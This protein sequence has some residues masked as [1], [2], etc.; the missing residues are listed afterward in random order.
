MKYIEIFDTWYSF[1]NRYVL[2]VFLCLSIWISFLFFF[3]MLEENADFQF[4]KDKWFLVSNIMYLWI[5]YS[6]IIH[7]WFSVIRTILTFLFINNDVRKKNIKQ[8]VKD[9]F[10]IMWKILLWTLLIP[11]TW[12]FAT[13]LFQIYTIITIKI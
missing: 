5:Y 2:L 4:T 3:Y 6:L 12:F 7:F 1:V 9:F 11:F 13:F 10:K 8:V